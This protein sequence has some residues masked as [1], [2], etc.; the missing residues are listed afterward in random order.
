MG[1]EAVI[2]WHGHACFTI[3]LGK[4]IIIDPF[5][6][7]NPVAKIKREDIIADIVVATHG[8]SDH[9]ADALPIATKNKAPIVTMVELAWLLQEKDHSIT[10]HDLNFS[11]FVNIKGIKITAVP[12]MHSSSY[13][14]KY[15]GNP[16]GMIL[17][18]GKIRIYHAGD[19]GLFSDM[20]MIGEVYRPDIA[21]LPIGGHYTMD[22]DDAIQ[23]IN[24]IKPKI[25]IPMH[26]NTFDMIKQDA[27]LF[28]KNVHEKTDAIAIVPLI[29]E[30]IKID[31]KQ[32]N[33]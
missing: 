27:E 14:E 18:N 25:V 28:R 13:E 2:T 33:N 17:D 29:E 5:I 3:D 6:E 22:P 26:F 4:K 10:I 12:A 11:G 16:G 19:T 1:T 23:A 20:K 32:L 7:H 8:H 24:M 15:A 21:M 30:E 31:S 9:V